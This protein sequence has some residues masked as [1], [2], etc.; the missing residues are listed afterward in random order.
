MRLT[1][2]FSKMSKPLKFC[3]AVPLSLNSLR[4]SKHGSGACGLLATVL[5]GICETHAAGYYLPNQDA[6]AT[7]RGNA[8]VATADS[9][10]AVHYNPAGLTQLQTTQAQVG[11]YGIQLGN[12]AETGGVRSSADYEWQAAP[13]VYYARPLNDDLT[14]GFGLNSPFGLGTDWGNDT[15]FRTVVTEARLLYASATAAVGYKATDT[16][17]IGLS[18]SLNYADLTLEQGLGFFPGDYLRFSGDAFALSA[19]L[20]MLWQ[21]HVQHS[22]GL[23]FHTPTSST[24]EG[25]VRSNLLP[26]SSGSLSFMTPARAAIGYSYRPAPGWNIEANIEWLDWDSLD[27]FRLR[28]STVNTSI[29][30]EWKSNLIYEIGASYTTPGGFVYALGYDLNGNAQPDRHFT[31]GV[32]DA[33]RHWLN[34]G[35]GRR[36]ESFSWFVTYQ[37]GWSDRRVTNAANPLVNGKYEAQHHAFVFSWQHAF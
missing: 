16:L 32:S 36:C 4:R 22:F 14:F 3:P 26:D 11:L 27:R 25:D 37:F 1:F 8:F 23:M 31:P 20:G 21:P 9:A 2:R 33:D 19:G 5:A 15:P 10:A 24:L 35:F 29:P 6:F 18:G 12:R 7:A 28:S 13:H 34:A 17:S 30:F